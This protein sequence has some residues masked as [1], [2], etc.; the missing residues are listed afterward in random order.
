MTAAPNASHRHLHRHPGQTPHHPDNELG[1]VPADP[2]EAG[3]L[4]G[5]IADAFFALP[6]SIWLVPA[7]HAHLRATVMRD[8]FTIAV[9]HAFHHGVVETVPNRSAVAV[10]FDNTTT[11]PKP[12]NY[13]LRRAAACG[14]FTERFVFLD[15]LLHSRHPARS[16]HHLAFLAVSPYTQGRGLGTAL[17]RHRLKAL[18]SAGVPSYLEAASQRLVGVYTKFGYQPGDQLHLAASGPPFTQMWR[19]P[20]TTAATTAV[21]VR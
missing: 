16:H 7:E 4:A 20:P 8:Y 15:D 13:E 12:D 18:D 2:S 5:L 10:W 11:Y 6:P 19:E 17:L 14:R 1:V 9:E 21:A 3:T